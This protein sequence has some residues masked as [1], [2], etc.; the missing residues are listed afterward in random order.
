MGPVKSTIMLHKKLLYLC[1]SLL[2]PGSAMALEGDKA[3]PA[4]AQRKVGY[5]T[6]VLPILER[7]CYSCHKG[8]KHKGDFRLDRKSTALRGGESGK[9]LRPGKSAE[10]LLIRS[11]M[12]LMLLV[13]SCL[14]LFYYYLSAFR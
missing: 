8:V 2:A 3:L 14:C 11:S 1:I 5:E 4:A 6:D 13:F 7:S 9:A 10:S 12:G